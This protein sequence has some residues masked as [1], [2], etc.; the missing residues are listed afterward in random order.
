[1]KYKIAF[2]LLAR[3]CKEHLKCNVE[4]IL[5]NQDKFEAVDIVI[6]ENDSVDGT[7]EY[8]KDLSKNNNNIHVITKDKKNDAIKSGD[9]SGSVYRIQRMAMYRNEYLEYIKKNMLNK[10]DYLIVL[11]ADIVSFDVVTL[12]HAIENAP[13]DFSALFANGRYFIDIFGKRIYLRYYDLFA[14]VPR[15]SKLTDLTYR[16]MALNSDLLTRK[17]IKENTYFACNSAFGG[18]GIY[19]ME[20]YSGQLYTTHK[21]QRSQYFDAVCEHIDFNM[22]FA[23]K[24]TNYIVSELL[25]GYEKVKSTKQVISVL[26]PA[27]VRLFVSERIFRKER[28]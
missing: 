20:K 19:K 7:K 22:E 1:M 6:V 15:E 4:R 18:I 5:G 11:D 24:G 3:D 13:K 25:V 26:F 21:N 17:H 23:Q 9:K 16:E 28:I 14:F 8:L 12:I 10:I 27:R 2:A